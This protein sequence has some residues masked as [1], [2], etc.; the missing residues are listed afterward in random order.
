MK[1]FYKFVSLGETPKGFS[2]LLDGKPVKTQSRHLLATPSRDLAN[3]VLQEWMAQGDKILPATMPLMQI[4]STKI[5]RVSIERG[6]MTA[7]LM[8]YLDTDLTCYRT[9]QP[10][11][12]GHQ[13]SAWDP[14]LGWFAAKFG[15]ALATTTALKALRQPEKAHEA[16]LDHIEA[17]EDEHFTILQIVTPLSGSLVLALA[18]VEGAMDA[19]QVFEAARV[20][21]IYKAELYNEK[22]HGPDPA[23]EKKDKEI[24]TD[25]DA[26]TKFLAFFKENT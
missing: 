16:V 24:R 4:L 25:L 17:L 8:K 12:D 19:D 5:D 13:K 15:V 6:A 14:W 2:I 23:Q 7:A 3:A 20:E 1:R 21:E 10:P 9:D 18:F 22:I 26:A 11:L